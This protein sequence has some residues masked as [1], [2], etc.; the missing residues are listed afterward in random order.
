MSDKTPISMLQ[1]LC[2]REDEVLMFEEVPH[3]FNPKMFSCTVN[4]F[5][6]FAEGSGRSKKEAKHE[7]SVNLLGE[8]FQ[9]EIFEFY[10][11]NVSNWSESLEIFLWVQTHL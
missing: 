3:K 2:N 9:I 10:C 6:A 11:W 7:A 5:N 4:A 1:E 8:W